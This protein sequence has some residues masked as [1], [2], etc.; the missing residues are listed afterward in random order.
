MSHLPWQRKWEFRIS[1]WG[2]SSTYNPLPQENGGSALKCNNSICWRHTK[3]KGWNYMKL[4]RH[5]YD[6]PQPSFSTPPF[7]LTQGQCFAYCRVSWKL[8]ANPCLRNFMAQITFQPCR[9]HLIFDKC[10]SLTEVKQLLTEGPSFMKGLQSRQCHCTVEVLTYDV[11]KKNRFSTFDQNKLD[12]WKHDG[13][14]LAS[15]YKHLSLLISVF[16]FFHHVLL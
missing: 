2:P 16:E 5:S 9:N 3:H 13:W 8:V 15:G 4:G 7:P 14:I 1:T 6:W 10:S 11:S 12:G